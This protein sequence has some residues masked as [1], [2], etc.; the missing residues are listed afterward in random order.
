MFNLYIFFFVDM[1]GADWDWDTVI[2][3]VGW[4]SWICHHTPASSSSSFVVFRTL[5]GIV[6]EA[7]NLR[8]RFGNHRFIFAAKTVR[9]GEARTRTHPAHMALA[10]VN[11]GRGSM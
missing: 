2:S 8:V 9:Q 5:C 4:A 7:F 3:Q 11:K 1:K 6:S 10:F